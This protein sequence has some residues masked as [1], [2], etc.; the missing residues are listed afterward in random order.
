MVFPS[1]HEAQTARTRGPCGASNMRL[2][3]GN[4]LAPWSPGWSCPDGLSQCHGHLDWGW[5]PEEPFVWSFRLHYLTVLLSWLLPPPNEGGAIM[6]SLRELVFAAS[7]EVKEE[8]RNQ[9]H[10]KSWAST[11][12]SGGGRIAC[13]NRR[14]RPTMQSS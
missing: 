8:R 4:Y 10:Q 6:E 9:T 5:K 11:Q 1:P 14:L 12:E 13:R 3:Q 7:H 2:L